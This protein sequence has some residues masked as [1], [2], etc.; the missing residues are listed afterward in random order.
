M[1]KIFPMIPIIVLMV[2]S[3]FAQELLVRHDRYYTEIFLK[4]DPK[5]IS[6]VEKKNA[7]VSVYFSK[8]IKNPFQ[9]PFKDRFI[10]SVSAS[11]DVFKVELYP[12][13]DVSIVNDPEGIKIVT[14]AKKTNSDIFLSYGIGS[15]LL[16]GSSSASEDQAQKDALDMA[17]KFITEKKFAEAAKLLNEILQKSK[18]DFYRQ[19]AMYR[20]GQTYMLLSQ[21]NDVYLTNA[22]TTFDDFAR[23]YPDN[24]RA[25]DAL[26]KSA[27]AKEKANQLF[28]A[29]FTYKKIYDSVPDLETK[30]A[31]LTKIASL[32]RTVGQYDKAVDAY[33]TYLDNFRT[34]SDE[35]LADMGQIYFDLKDTPTAYEY[36][37]SLDLD[38]LI[39][40]PAT[41]SRRLYSVARTMEDNK[42]YPEALKLYAALYEKFPDAKE[43]NDAIFKSADILRLTDQ[44][45]KADML[46]LKLKETY[47][48]R[49]SGQK[50]AVEYARKYLPSKPSDYWKDFFKDL[51]AREDS[52]GLQG[53]A[54]YLIIKSMSAEN[55]AE[56]SIAAIDSYLAAYPSS[57]YFKELDKI[58]E[59]F[60]FEKG[61][62]L[63]AAKDYNAAEKV[64]RKFNADYPESVYRPS[65]DA[66][67]SDI[68]FAKALALYNGNKFK[69]AASEAEKFIAETGSSQGAK[70]W[71]DLLDNS[72]Y[73]YLNNLYG[74]GDYSGALLNAKEYLNNFPD[75]A[76]AARVR[77]ILENSILEPIGKDY[78]A[79]NYQAVVN[80]YEA[81][82]DWIKSMKDQKAKDEIVSISGLSVYRLGAKDNA[83][84]LYLSLTPNDNKNYALLGILTGDKDRNFDVNGFDRPTF[85]YIINEV[86]TDH[87]DWALKLIKQYTA[88]PKLSAKLEYAIAKST[89]SDVKRQE[90]LSDVYDVIKGSEAARFDGSRDVYLDMGVMYFGKNDFKNAVMPLKQFLNEYKAADEKRA[91]AL[92]YMGKSFVKMGDKDRGFQYYNEII[93]TIPDS[94]YAS[95]A[96]SEMDENLWKDSLRR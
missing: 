55:K 78:A 28:E 59:D 94:I 24:F 84:K 4:L 49:Q 61:S 72:S 79:G 38:K 23:L 32:Y 82:S 25:S 8:K 43:A 33:Q 9:K 58:R 74:I 56:A 31:A 27:E 86:K 46:L 68:R 26:M 19:E 73:K 64:L 2:S 50:A 83:K 15:P 42:K 13:A 20:L 80:A 35:V 39:K 87:P 6:N 22:Y 1:T 91:E 95:V 44:D 93:N 85:E 76:N 62:G 16:S 3:A 57:K 10:K 89:V 54:K 7:E 52:F 75:R 92:Y 66:I 47:P 37:S 30:R 29:I 17:D 77:D 51:L 81:S 67:L 70:R 21:I 11:G 12:G 45:A 96:K 48:D 53:E 41:D 14:S 65:S 60:T 63:F 69:D 88:D 36:F 40:N 71:L 34:G 5:T 18:N 90:I